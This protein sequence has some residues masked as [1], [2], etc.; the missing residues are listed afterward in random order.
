MKL[1]LSIFFI[2]SFLIPQIKF[3]EYFLDKTL[4]IDYFHTGNFETEYYSIDELIEEPFWGGS[5]INLLDKFNY[6]KY[7]ITVYDSATN[8]LIYSRTYSTLFSEWQTTQEAKSTS[9]SFN[10][11]MTIPFPRRK[12][13]VEF[14]S[15]NRKNEF[16]KNFEYNIDPQN[17][18]IKKE[19]TKEYNSFQVLNSG[20]SSNKVD[21]VFLPEGYTQSEIDLFKED[22][23]KFVDYF[24]KSSPFIENKDKF[25]FWGV[26][27]PSKESGTDFPG[28]GLWNRTLLNTQF[29]TFNT[30]RYLMTTDDKSVRDVA[31]NAPYDQI[32]ILVNTSEYGGGAIYN[33]Y[34]VCMNNNRFEEQV[35]VHEFGHGFASLADEYVTDDVSYQNFYEL[36]I[37]PVDPNLTTLVDFNSKWK[38]L[39]DGDTPIPTP[40]TKDYKNKAGAFEGAGYVPKGIYRPMLECT[41]RSSIANEFCVVCKKAIQDMIDFYTE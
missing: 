10:E 5:K 21:I 1:L 20:E 36:D 22:C 24:F 18:F 27:A 16:I 9:R 3:E 41:M 4:R 11:T 7:K 32:Y 40:E 28:K 25:N 39:V 17:Y 30:E 15:R 34:S 29:Y 19:R 35:F 8:N 26:E 37:E 13:R 6:G 33:Y 31:S 38:N 14:Y 2:N 12:V 23:K